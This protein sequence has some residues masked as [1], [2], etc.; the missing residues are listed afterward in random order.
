MAFLRGDSITYHEKIKSALNKA[1]KEHKKFSK[2]EKTQFKIN[3]E[4]RNCDCILKY[5]PDYCMVYRP[6]KLSEQLIIFEIIDSQDEIKTIADIMRIKL[7]FSLLF[8]FVLVIFFPKSTQAKVNYR[9]GNFTTRS[10]ESGSILQIS[11]YQKYHKSIRGFNMN[12]KFTLI[13]IITIFC[14]LLYK[15]I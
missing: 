9:P 7:L 11:N 10:I 1:C 12:N 4:K 8:L 6:S 5:E 15:K 14:F 2:Y 13:I 3:C